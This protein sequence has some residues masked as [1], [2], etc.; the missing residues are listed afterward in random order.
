MHLFRIEVEPSAHKDDE[1]RIAAAI[2]AMPAQED[3]FEEEEPDYGVPHD[4]NNDSDPD[5][6]STKPEKPIITVKAGSLP[7]A[8]DEA[9][10]YLIG[11][12]AVFQRG[13]RLVRV[14]EVVLPRRKPFLGLIE[15]RPHNLVEIFTRLITWKKYD[16][17][18]KDYRQCDCPR[19]VAATYLERVG[20]WKVPPIHAVIT[21]PTLREDGSILHKP[22]LDP[23]TGIYFDPCGVDFPSVPLFPSRDDARGALDKLIEL[24]RELPFTVDEDGE[25]VSRSIF[26]AAFLS[27]LVRATLPAA[28]LFAFDA[29][30]AGSGKSM[31]VDTITIAMTG[32]PASVLSQG[33][34]EEE[35]EK[36][37]AGVLMA[38][39]QV[40]SFDNCIRPIQGDLLCQAVT[41]P[42][43][44]LRIL[45]QSQTCTVVNSA[46]YFATGNNLV[47]SGDMVRRTLRATIDPQ[48]ETPESRVFTTERPDKLVQQKRPEYVIT[49][50]TVLRA[51]I[52]AQRPQQAQPL[53]SLETWSRLVRDALIWLGEPDP[54]R[55]ISTA[56]R[57]DPAREKTATVLREWHAAFEDRPVTA[58]Q[59]KDFALEKRKD[60][61][62]TNR[63][64]RDALS[65]VSA[66][67]CVDAAEIGRWA[68]ANKDRI[69]DGYKLSEAGVLH[70][71]K[72]WRVERIN[73]APN[74]DE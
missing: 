55:A 21:A 8:I 69:I 44:K 34:S 54:C 58:A 14:G 52:V 42:L 1:Q 43:L 35:L 19:E 72:R 39:D 37:L 3:D 73:A 57:S 46:M 15:V 26:L 59:V 23:Q 27:A 5:L 11:S 61:L 24:V 32:E 48:T 16:G 65:A 9:E 30:E 64:I 12:N 13:G 74:V 36:R 6:P 45:G 4:L 22:G 41:Q 71:Y 2:A 49:G 47:V 10:R 63:A 40:I 7:D 51:Y 20:D 29:P 60:E 68:R 56:R 67:S 18:S 38:G 50:L 17:R 28:P 66:S 31:L 70:G 33:H 62:L 53:G 25:P